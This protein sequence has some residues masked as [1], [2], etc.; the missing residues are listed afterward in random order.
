MAYDA[1][2]NAVDFYLDILKDIDKTAIASPRIEITKYN[3]ERPIG[4]FWLHA[5]TRKNFNN[6][7]VFAVKFTLT[8]RE[9]GSL[10]QITLEEYAT[11]ED[12]LETAIGSFRRENFKKISKKQ[13]HF[14]G[15]ENLSRRKSNNSE[16]IVS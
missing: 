15:D 1:I 5:I 16:E 9:E 7:S 12:E 3:W 6:N 14:R 13:R 11:L 8:R 4:T 2:Q 10:G